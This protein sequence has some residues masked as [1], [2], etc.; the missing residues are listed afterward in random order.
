MFCLYTTRAAATGATSSGAPSNKA[1][2]WN[3]RASPPAAGGNGQRSGCSRCCRSTESFERLALIHALVDRQS[4]VLRSVG[5]SLDVLGFI[6][7]IR[8][9]PALGL[10][11]AQAFAL[12]E[13]D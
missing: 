12:R 13:T 7:K 10:R 5:R 3:T 9:E 8:R 11:E 4:F 2:P 1:S 6:P